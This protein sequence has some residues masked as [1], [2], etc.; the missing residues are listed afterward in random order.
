MNFQRNSQEH[1]DACEFWELFLST[2]QKMLDDPKGGGVDDAP[3]SKSKI[4]LKVGKVVSFIMNWILCFFGLHTLSGACGALWG[5]N[6]ITQELCTMWLVATN[7]LIT[8]FLQIKK[9]T[10]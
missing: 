6:H 4:I 2:K 8:I 9:I 10:K 1:K 7:Y 3:E 5:F